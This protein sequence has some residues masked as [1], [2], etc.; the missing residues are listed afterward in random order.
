MQKELVEII[1]NTP[2]AKNTYKMV[3][4][5]DGTLYKRPGMFMNIQI[6]NKF[7][8]RPISIC[9]MSEKQV[10]IIYKEVGEGTA[11]LKDQKPG[12]KL[13][14]ISPL[15]N[16][17]D[18]DLKYEMVVAGGL[19]VAPVYSLV[20]QLDSPIVVLGFRSI[21]DAFLIEEFQK[22]TN[23]LY[24]CTDDGSYGYKG[25]I[26]DLIKEKGFTNKTYYCCGPLP[27][28]KNLKKIMTNKG[29]LSLEERMG[30]GFG[31]CMG[32]SI[33]TSLGPKRVCKEGPVF[34][35]E[36]LLWED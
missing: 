6:E 4:S 33:M 30:C 35:S 9:D 24:V 2:I 31:A 12:K 21:A 20:K 25:F 10:T 17:F 13:D 32:C 27:M 8:R 34:H 16:G 23:N 3:L 19:G 18:T 5:A 29:L 1:S 28:M 26:T 7:L 11:W 15:G 14:V 22:N 36:E